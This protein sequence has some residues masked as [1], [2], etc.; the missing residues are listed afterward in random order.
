[1]VLVGLVSLFMFRK[2]EREAVRV[3]LGKVRDV[4][5]DFKFFY[6]CI[7]DIIVIIF[8]VLYF[9]GKKL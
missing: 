6:K 4:C 2:G 1:M 9:L 3:W 5:W 7:V 8:F